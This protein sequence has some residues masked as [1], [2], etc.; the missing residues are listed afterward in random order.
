MFFIWNTFLE[1]S[2]STFLSQ[3]KKT[4]WWRK[5]QDIEFPICS[6][7]K[8]FPHFKILEIF[9]WF[10]LKKFLRPSKKNNNNTI[11]INNNNSNN[12]NA[13]NCNNSNNKSHL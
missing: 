13:A 11:A 6:E 2:V 10:D 4:F 12:T 3:N 5:N 1:G 9:S 8:L 7:K